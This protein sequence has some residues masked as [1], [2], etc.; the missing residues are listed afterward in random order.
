MAEGFGSLRVEVTIGATRWQTSIFP[1]NKRGTCVL[2][3]KK[4]VRQ[5]ED[6][7][8]ASTSTI[9]LAVLE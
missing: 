8:D 9:E 5:A 3:V 2:P 1:D 6:L 4:A 7:G